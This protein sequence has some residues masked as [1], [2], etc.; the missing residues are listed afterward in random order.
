MRADLHGDNA[1]VISLTM[2]DTTTPTDRDQRTGQ[3][4]MGHKGGP[5]RRAGSRNRITEE[6]LRMFA[7]DVAEHG[8]SVIETVRLTKPE[9]YLRVWADL[10]P[11]EA[12]LDV[13]VDILHDVSN[14]LEAYRR[15][16]DLI[17]ADARPGVRK[18]KRAEIVDVDRAG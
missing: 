11:R 3:F 13:N 2:T 9:V 17:G 16:A 4:Q 5:G 12:T 14:A 10:L 8:A 15:M 18:L 6:L 1:I 7:D